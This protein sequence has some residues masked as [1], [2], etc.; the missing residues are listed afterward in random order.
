METT[1][2]LH[3]APVLPLLDPMV[4]SVPPPVQERLTLVVCES[5]IPVQVSLGDLPLLCSDGA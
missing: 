2:L 4:A 3:P 1:Q 5:I